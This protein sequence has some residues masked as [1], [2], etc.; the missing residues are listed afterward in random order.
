MNRAERYLLQNDR[1]L[2]AAAFLLRRGDQLDL[3]L[4][5]YILDQGINLDRFITRFSA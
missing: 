5:T 3:D 1:R 2:R 4:Q